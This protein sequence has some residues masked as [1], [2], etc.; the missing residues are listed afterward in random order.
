LKVTSAFYDESEWALANISVTVVN[1]GRR[2]A[3]LRLLGGSNNRGESSG[4]FFESIGGGMRLGEHERHDL[5]IERKDAFAIDPDGPDEPYARMWVEDSLGNRYSVSRSR[6]Y[7]SK[8][9]G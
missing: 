1:V 9:H 3:I 5:T 8:A 4:T 2:P 7:L 6:E